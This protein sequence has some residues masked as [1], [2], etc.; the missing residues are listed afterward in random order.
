MTRVRQE[1]P[2]GGEG[3]AAAWLRPDTDRPARTGEPEVVFGQGKTPQ[4]CADAVAALLAADGAPVLVTRAGAEAAE[5]VRR[6]APD[7]RYDD[8][9]RVVVA[10][11]A[12]AQP[13]RVAIATGGTSDLPVARECAVVLEAFGLTSELVADVGV[14]GVH[15]LLDAR[16]DLAA[17]D[18]VVAIAGMEGALPNAVAGLV[19]APVVAV[20]TSVGY[21]AAFDGIAALLSMLSSC[22]PGVV[23]VN[24]D[25]G[26]SAAI[27]AR[28]ILASRSLGGGS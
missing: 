1:P 9:A 13:G 26:F 17:A 25:A 27:A 22:A 14:A 24:I 15:R 20:P 3:Q 4:Q 6:V 2:A 12:P 11:S 16:D 5:A 21:G 10:R 18:V 7:A 8:D 19:S 23:V 28:R